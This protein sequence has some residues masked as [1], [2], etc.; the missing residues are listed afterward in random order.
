MA[1]KRGKTQARRSGGGGGG[2]SMP[3]WAWLVIG[4]A[5]TLLVVLAAPKLMHRDKDGFFRPTPNPDALP[6]P[7]DGDEAVVDDEP[8]DDKAATSK[9]APADDAKKKQD[10]DFYTLLPG[11]EVPMTDAELAASEQAEKAQ[12]VAPAEA[13]SAPATPVPAS[14]TADAK[15]LP[16]PI[17]ESPA[18]PASTD[19]RPPATAGAPATPA[20]ASASA[21]DAHYILQAGAFQASGQAEELKA[22]IALLGLGARVESAQIGGKT[23]Y[24]VRMGPYGSASELAEAKRKLASGGLSAMAVKTN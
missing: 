14:A 15:P 17:D 9:P 18:K 13:P 10:F 6:K 11:K 2:G 4:V 3:G 23:V 8:V 7:A 24:R 12:K 22:K 19:N 1:Q 20:A 16:A 21:P 5:V